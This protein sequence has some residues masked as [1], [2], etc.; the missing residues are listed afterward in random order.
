MIMK[1]ARVVD[2]HLKNLESF[3]QEYRLSTDVNVNLMHQSPE[4]RLPTSYQLG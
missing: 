2:K 4:K 3:F 1:C